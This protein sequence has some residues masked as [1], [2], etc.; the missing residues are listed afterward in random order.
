MAAAELEVIDLTGLSDSSGGEERDERDEEDFGSE[1]GSDV[2]EVEITLNSETREQL[3]TALSTVSEGRLRQVLQDLIQ[4]DQAVEIALTRELVTLRRQTRSVVPRWE[5]C[6]NCEEEYDINTRREEDEC[7]FH[8][9]ELEVV[10]ERFKDWDENVHG[11]M[12]TPENQ[13]EYPDNF[14][15]TCCDEDGSAGGCVHGEH[16]PAV[17]RKRRRI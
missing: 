10:Y 6:G 9:G 1:S 11:E 3:R 8:P 13:R 17:S 2:S 15:W 12:D 4:E 16:K 5:M 7:S 14:I